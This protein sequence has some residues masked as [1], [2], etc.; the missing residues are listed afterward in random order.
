M[1][2]INFLHG[3]NVYAVKREYGKEVIDFSANINP[4]GLTK[5]IKRELAKCYRLIAHYPDPEAKDLIGEIAKYW[6]IDGQNI[7]IGNGSTEL[8]YLIAHAFKPEKILIPVPTFSEYERACQI[9]YKLKVTSYKLKQEDNFDINPD[10]FISS[11]RTPNSNPPFPPLL[12]GGEGGLCDIAFLCNPN[13][14]TGKLLKK[15]GILKI[16]DAAKELKCYLIIDEAF[17]DFLPDEKSHTFIWKAVKDKKIIVLRSFTKFFA[18]PGLRIGYLVAHKN[19]IKRLKQIQ[20]P[21]SVNSI[22]QYL[23]QILLN[24]KDYIEKTHKL[25]NEERE[26]LF[27]EL[28]KIKALRPYPSVTNFLLIKILNNQ[29]DSSVLTSKLIEKEILIRDCSNFRGL[30]SRYFRVAVRSH[31]ENIK[32]LNA[33][34]E[35]L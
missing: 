1:G 15:D 35:I 2:Y 5:A 17:M 18:L 7:V 14:P 32:F 23:A 29:I 16:A 19:L 33:L 28:T 12:K 27:N 30:N 13:N 24:D 25:I 3:G 9:S 31:K 10:E 22:A 11:L 4:L 26:F 8:I 6:K 34:R 21:W 20:S